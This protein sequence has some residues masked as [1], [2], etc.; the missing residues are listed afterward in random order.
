MP[1][2][3]PLL[4]ALA[5]ALAL[6]A[7]ASAATTIGQ[8]ATGGGTCD[9]DATIAQTGSLAPEYAVPFAGVVTELRTEAVS[10]EGRRLHVLRPRGSGSF[11]LLA[12]IPVAPAA[13]VIAVPVR[14]RVQAGDV[15]GL[16]TAAAPDPHP[17]C[18]IPNSTG[19]GAS[20]H[21]VVESRNPA[22]P[23]SGDVTLP[24]AGLGR[25][26]V[27]ATLE[28]DG[29]GDGFGDETQDRCPDDASRTTQDCAADLF[30]SQTPTE[31][32]VERDDVNVITVSVRNN[33]PSPARNARVLLPMPPGVQFVAATPTGGGCAGGPPVDCTFPSIPSGATGSVLVVVKA[34]S[35]GQKTLTA[36]VGSPTPDPNGANNSSELLFD[37][38]ARRSVVEPGAFCRVPRLTGLTRTSARRALEA[39]GCRLGRTTRKRYRSGRYGRVRAQSIP[40][41]TRVATRTRVN[42]TLRRR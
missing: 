13:G 14:V 28:P 32:E 30:V 27:A 38:R 8:T 15:L 16:S 35:L 5:A 25:L 36:T 23:D 6:P 19:A 29:D 24:D 3:R 31:T 39:A 37:V 26:N 42:I 20:P 4:A 11:T 21:N 2:L 22:A 7:T 41:L 40:A 17:N 9:N 12:S 18:T 1:R 10:V 34:I 33:G